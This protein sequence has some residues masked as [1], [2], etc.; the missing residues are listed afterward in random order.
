MYKFIGYRLGVP[1]TLAIITFPENARIGDL[2]ICV[3][4]LPISTQ[5]G[6]PGVKRDYAVI[7]LHQIGETTNQY[8]LHVIACTIP[9][10]SGNSTFRWLL[11]NNGGA[12]TKYIASG[13][14]VYRGL[15]PRYTPSGGW[16]LSTA[17]QPSSNGL[18]EIAALNEFPYERRGI[19][20]CAAAAKISNISTGTTQGK[21]TP[22]D[23]AT[24]WTISSPYPPY[25]F[26][27]SDVNAGG[28][29]TFELS[30][31]AR[32]ATVAWV[33]TPARDIITTSPIQTRKGQ[34]LTIEIEPYWYGSQITEDPQTIDAIIL[35]LRSN[36]DSP[37]L[38]THNQTIT[39][40]NEV[41][42]LTIPS[43]LI[44]T[45][46]LS[47][48]LYRVTLAIGTRRYG[49]QRGILQILPA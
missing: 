25:A 34:A 33:E 22:I 40:P 38:F 41:Y 4:I 15:D 10:E 47:E 36:T 42:T 3:A 17:M 9:P 18:S 20:V 11:S 6:Y 19:I 48:Y 39:T 45:L 21:S 8:W 2:I 14:F 28:E 27:V 31:P 35:T 46:T 30:T 1:G 32:W 5:I 7:Q 44:D 16:E 24:S 29:F 43:N 26:T 12:F 37:I 13:V 23:P 49:V